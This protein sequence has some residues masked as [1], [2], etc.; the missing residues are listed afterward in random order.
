MKR[1]GV[2]GLNEGN[3][4]PISFSAAFNGYDE[5]ALRE[6]PFVLIRE[7]LPREQRNEVFIDGARVT[8]VWTQDKKLSELTARIAKIPHIVDNMEDLI[9]QVDAV[10]LLRDD[11]ENH[12]RMAEPFLKARIPLYVDKLIAHNMEDLRKFIRAAGKG[13]PFMSGSPSRYTRHTEQAK[14]G[15]DVSKVLTIHGVSR[16]T[17]L[18]YAPHL[19]DSISTLFGLDVETVQ[20]VGEEGF[21]IVH[22]RYRSGPHV[23]LQITQDMALPIEYT[24]YA[25]ASRSLEDKGGKKD[26]AAEKKKLDGH[27]RV[28]FIDYFHCFRELLIRFTRMLE[29]GTPPI[30]F[31]D[32]VNGSKVVI[33]GDISRRKGNRVVRISDLN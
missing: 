10:L 2:V 11:V 13:C 32:L 7:Y 6:C 1:I 28:P 3:G 29:T 5:K 31:D 26:A 4:H 14:R 22:I 15:L 21:D 8:H 19:F 33:A 23:I 30:P 24:C 12:W 27:Y 16:C 20:N 17:W 18:R 25:T 9:G